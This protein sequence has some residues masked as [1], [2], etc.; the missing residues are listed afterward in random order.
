MTF[1]AC[2]PEGEPGRAGG[3]RGDAGRHR[4]KD[5]GAVGQ[6]DWLAYRLA[7]LGADVVIGSQAHRPQTFEF[8]RAAD[9]HEAFIHYGLG[10]LFFDQTSWGKV[11]FFMD[12]L[13]IYD[14]R[15]LTVDLFT[16]LIEDRGRPR[17]MTAEE[18]EEFL[19][20]M[21]VELAAP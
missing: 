1:E 3:D 10:N 13:F 2:P 17:P 11:R 19:Q 9:G 7:D 18:S 6:T 16:G 20:F 12:Q 21:F 4:W 8:Y 15:L 14:G 5:Q